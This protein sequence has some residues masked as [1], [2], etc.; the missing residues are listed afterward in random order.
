LGDEVG[1]VRG[2]LISRR[3]GD[4]I[5]SAVGW[6]MGLEE[7]LIICISE[8]SGH[9]ASS[10]TSSSPLSAGILSHDCGGIVR[11]LEESEEGGFT[12]FICT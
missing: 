5:D 2:A 11:E 3:V 10:V 6:E 9:S 12:E 4:G 8:A 1:V 7:I